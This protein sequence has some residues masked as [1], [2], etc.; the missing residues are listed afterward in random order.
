[1]FTP[2]HPA[3]F[4]A[5]GQALLALKD[6]G[7]EALMFANDNPAAGAILAGQRAG[8]PSP[9]YDVIL[10]KANC[11]SKPFG[12]SLEYERTRALEASGKEEHGGKGVAQAHRRGLT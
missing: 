10:G 3:L 4:E 8:M 9:H 5:G 11:G 7:V 12:N 2:E 1:M 6:N